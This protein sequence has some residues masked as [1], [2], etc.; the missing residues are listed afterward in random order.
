M[1]NGVVFIAGPT[2]SGKS[3]A[4]LAA[5]EAVG[6]EIVNADA[7]Q[8][9]RD[10]RILTARPSEAE[11]AKAP[12]HLY[13]VLDG[14]ERCSAGRWA[15]MAARVIE[16]VR[17]RGRPAII[18]GGTGLYFR[19]LEEGLSPIPD[20]PAAIRARAKARHG[21]IGAEAFREEVVARDPPMARLAVAD[22]QRLLRA[23]EVHEATGRALSDYQ[24]QSG[25]PLIEERP[26]KI[27]I[28]PDR[29]VLYG[30]CDERAAAMLEAGAVAEV[31]GLLARGLDPDLPVMKALGVSET[32]DFLRGRS[33][34][35]EALAALQQTTRRFAKRQ[36]TW[37][38]NQA[39][40]WPRVAGVESAVA[41]LS[42]PA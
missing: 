36:L 7:M 24:S 23:W 20:V 2:A 42:R 33:T 1:K 38:R 18:V 11:E 34:R 29:D 27:V 25:T 12:H 37:F 28:E 4:A 16:D 32:A 40:D 15:R 17:R 14:R 41:E 22:T 26:R 13:G 19:A 9:Y 35:D 21:E 39:A 6:G 30:R 10:L 3:A 31:E 5:A 8:V